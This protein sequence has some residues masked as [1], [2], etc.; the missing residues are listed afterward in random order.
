MENLKYIIKK[1]I[2]LVV[3]LFFVSM[4]AFLIFEILP[5]DSVTAMLGTNYSPERA[6]ALREEMG[7]NDPVYVRYFDWLK[8][9][10]SGDMGISF[11]YKIPVADVLAEKLPV[12]LWLAAISLIL[13]T[14]V[15]LPL[16]VL[17]AWREHKGKGII[18][19]YVNQFIMSIPSF[20]LGI[21]LIVVF[22]LTFKWF[23]PGAYVSYRE[24]F[25]EFLAYIF[26]A[27]FAIAIPKTAM[28]V[29]FTKSTMVGE[30]NSDYVRTAKSK[31]VSTFRLLFHHVFRNGLLPVITFLGMIIAEVMAG[32]I[33]VEQV[34]NIPGI[35]RI[36]VTAVSNRD[37]P[38]VQAIIVYIAAVVIIV[39]CIVDIIYRYIDPRVTVGIS[40]N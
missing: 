1:I 7:L 15:S 37:Y 26:P 11:K 10:V 5:G 31:G 38:V 2:T 27:A 36:M 16:G 17:L 34:F 23:T 14:I 3:T 19:E 28:V 40:S 20:F 18:M 13:T 4:I 8:N 30:L 24:N 33:I 21:V 12:T 39:N 25:G 29:K 6:E 32:S 9:F 35:G 22:G